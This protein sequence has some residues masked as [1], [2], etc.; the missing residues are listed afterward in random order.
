[1]VIP[2]TLDEIAEAERLL[3]EVASWSDE[4]VQALPGLYRDQAKRY[5]EQLNSG[6]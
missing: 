3:E 6:D 4:E 5:R 1:M 2:V